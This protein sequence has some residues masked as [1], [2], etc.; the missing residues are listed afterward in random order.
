MKKVKWYIGFILAVT[1]QLGLLAAVPAKKIVPRLA[2]KKVVLKI[3]PVDPYNIMSGYFLSLDY[4]IS[5]PDSL[6]GWDSLREHQIVYAIL[7]EGQDG[8]W[9]AMSLHSDRPAAMP[10]GTVAI[11]GR[12]DHW[13]IRYGIESYYIPEKGRK[14]IEADLRKHS[15]EARA[16]VFVGPFGN[17]AIFRVWVQDR[18]YQY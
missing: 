2:G 5:H 10:E 15:D 1:L 4:E 17:A 7:E 6:E 8:L 3:Q 18:L 13:R 12:K 14:K 9:H 16:E 11:K